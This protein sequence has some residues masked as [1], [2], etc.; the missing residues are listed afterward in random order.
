MIGDCISKYGEFGCEVYAYRFHFLFIFIVA[1]MGYLGWKWLRR[2]N[3]KSKKIFTGIALLIIGYIIIS[4][5]WAVIVDSR[6][7]EYTFAGH[8]NNWI[9]NMVKP[10]RFLWP[11]YE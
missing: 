11:R 4:A 10:N 7:F 5:L 6:G 3:T 1:L 9:Y 2:Y 8:V